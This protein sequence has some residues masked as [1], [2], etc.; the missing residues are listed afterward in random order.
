MYRQ[1]INL[2]SVLAVWLILALPAFAQNT[3]LQDHIDRYCKSTCITADKLSSVASRAAK[4]Y[5]LDKHMVIAIIHV[6]SKYNYKAKN[7][8]SI[9][10]TQVLL[11][12]H[13]P[14]FL[15]KNYFDIEDNIFAGMQVLR[16]CLQKHKGSYPRAITCYNGGGDKHY[17]SKVQAVYK[18]VRSLDIP[19]IAKDPLGHFIQDLG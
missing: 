9:G 14:K 18:T 12:Y 7:G 16:D 13:K 15:G 10:L 2:A 19:V 11:K 8:S 5:G 3:D 6:E 4:R 1:F 17:A